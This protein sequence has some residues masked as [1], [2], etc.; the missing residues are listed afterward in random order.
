MC[1]PFFFS[2]ERTQLLLA[3]AIIF[4]LVYL[5]TED[6]FQLLSLGLIITSAS[7]R[8]D[9]LVLFVI[10]E[11]ND[12]SFP[13]LRMMLAVGLSWKWSEV[14][15]SCLI[16]CDPMD[17]S[18]PGSS[19]EGILRREYWSG[20]PFPSP[21]DWT[22]VSST[23]GRLPS[24]PPGKLVIYALYYVEAGSPYAHFLEIFFSPS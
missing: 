4:I 20:L 24:E 22:R 12:L 7:V 17:C 5:F 14:A 15:Q 13:P 21:G 6:R 11:G 10:L 18:P 23:A 16:L 19:I 9:I 2:P 1:G 3:A 8:V